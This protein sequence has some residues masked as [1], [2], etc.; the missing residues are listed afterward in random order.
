MRVAH[1]VDV[2]DLAGQIEDHVLPAHQIVHR[3]LL[4]DVGDVDAQ[5][6]FEAADVEQIAAVVV[7]Q[8]VDDQDAR[9]EVDELPREVAADEAEAAGD[10]H[11]TI[12]IEPAVVGGVAAAITRR[13]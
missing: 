8:R 9:A 1:A 6:V 11:R 4:A 3:R 7:D 13:F 5:P 12:A 10:H 2:A